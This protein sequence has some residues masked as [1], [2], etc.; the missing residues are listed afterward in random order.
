MKPRFFVMML[1]LLA[2]LSY[3][4]LMAIHLSDGST[5]RIPL[6]DINKLTFTFGGMSLPGQ[7][8]AL[9][10]NHV[11]ANIYPNPFNPSTTISY[12]LPHKG[13]VSIKVFDSKGRLVRILET[14]VFNAGNHAVRWD[15]K[16]ASGRT[17]SSGNYISQILFAG[18]SL[19]QKLILI[20]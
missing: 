15:G 20:K 12:S 3:C 1:A 7:S 13:L 11:F 9:K 10:L 17:V 14:N 2:S 6:S 8:L 5:I 4:H 18:K 19:S 16:D